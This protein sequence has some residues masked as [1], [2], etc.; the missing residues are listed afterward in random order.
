MQPELPAVEA[1]DDKKRKKTKQQEA[2][3][4]AFVDDTSKRTG[5]AKAAVREELRIGELPEDV[6]A[7]A[8]ETPVSNNKREL[9]ALTRMPQEEQRRAVA[10]VKSGESRT[11]RPKAAKATPSNDAEAPFDLTGDA[12]TSQLIATGDPESYRDDP[13]SPWATP[14]GA[15]ERE[16]A[17][18]QIV[19]LVGE[20]QRALTKALELWSPSDPD[21]GRRWVRDS[22]D[23]VE[24]LSRWME[25]TSAQESWAASA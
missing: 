8:R 12:T 25:S 18:A 9:L 3:L 19:R 5:R 1:G 20:A 6:R 17:R 14:G 15:L 22:V 2:P 23:A 24:R 4:M 16:L 13:M 11:V 21:D 7:V 10:A